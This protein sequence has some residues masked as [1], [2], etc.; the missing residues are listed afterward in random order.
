[1]WS[2]PASSSAETSNADLGLNLPVIAATGEAL[3]VTQ[4]DIE[5]GGNRYDEI[6]GRVAVLGATTTRPVGCI[7]QTI[8]NSPNSQF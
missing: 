1:M 4:A 6:L 5:P 8:R 3:G 7:E 2:R